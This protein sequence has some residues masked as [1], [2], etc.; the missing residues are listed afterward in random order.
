M[1]RYLV[2]KFLYRVD[3]DEASLKAYMENSVA[4]V[5]MWEEEQGPKLNES[6]TTSAH[7]FTEEERKALAERDF[8]KLYAMGAHPFLLWTLMLPIFEREFP[9]FRALVDHY[10]SKIR[11]YGRPDFGT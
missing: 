4:F 5:A 1:S 10:N 6:E 3:R 7:R 11:S 2:D 8:E 9:N